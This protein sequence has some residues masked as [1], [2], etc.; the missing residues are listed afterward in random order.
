MH[1]SQISLEQTC[2]LSYLIFLDREFK[3][4]FSMTSVID[5]QTTSEVTVKRVHGSTLLDQ[6]MDVLVQLAAYG[7]LQSSVLMFL[8]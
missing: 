6:I 8:S 2:C 5:S 1:K 4:N 3:L 7:F